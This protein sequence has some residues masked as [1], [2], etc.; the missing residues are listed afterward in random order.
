MDE[1]K[2][3]VDEIYNFKGEW[4]I[5]SK[6]GLKIIDKKDRTIIIVTE[7]YKSNPGTSVTNWNTHLATE[8]CV[9]FNIHPEKMIF[10]EHAPEMSSRFSFYKETFDR[11]SFDWDGKSF[12]NPRW[13]RITREEIYEL[14]NT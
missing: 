6:C 10:I 7:F 1:E 14:I 2:S 8:L 11:V 12:S 13:E 5:P 4:G 3:F 9:K